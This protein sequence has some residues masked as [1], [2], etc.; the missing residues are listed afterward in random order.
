MPKG[1]PTGA[2]SGDPQEV[3]EGE[4]T[5]EPTDELIVVGLEDMSIEKLMKEIGVV[6][7]MQQDMSAYIFSAKR[8]GNKKILEQCYRNAEVNDARMGQYLKEYYK[9]TGKKELPLGWDKW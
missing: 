5:N 9:R 3:R 2:E 1:E 8:E 4:P 7:R 6:G